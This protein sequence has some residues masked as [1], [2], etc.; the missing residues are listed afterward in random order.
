MKIRITEL[1]DMIAEAIKRTLAEAPKG[2][3]LIPPETEE[4][5]EERDER[6]LRGL[7]GYYHSEVND[8]SKPLGRKNRAKRQGASGIGGWTSE[9]KKIE[10]IKRRLGEMKIRKLVKMIAREEVKARGR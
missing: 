8:F 7:S 9:A 5:E 3:K 10:Y 6:Q 2:A 1:R 4:S